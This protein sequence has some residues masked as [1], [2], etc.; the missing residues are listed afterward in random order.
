MFR[1]LEDNNIKYDFP[2][3]SET[4]ISNDND[5]YFS[6]FVV[7]ILLKKNLIGYFKN[8][9]FIDTLIVAIETKIYEYENDDI[10]ETMEFFYVIRNHISKII[11][12]INISDCIK[13]KINK[14]LEDIDRII[15]KNNC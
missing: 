14:I 8:D 7:D 2:T 3:K 4:N 10:D 11:L 6:D 5:L 9:V 13:A 15:S 12:Q 1:R